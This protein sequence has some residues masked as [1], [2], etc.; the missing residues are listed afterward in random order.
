MSIRKRILPRSGD[1]RWQVDYRDQG[2]KRRAK[3]FTTKAAAVSYET[4]ARGE[5]VAGTHVADSASITVKEAATIWL[6]SCEARKL[7]ESSVRSYRNHVRRHIE[8]LIGDLKRSRR[9]RR[10]TSSTGSRR[11]ATAPPS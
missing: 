6:A 1:V 3:Q 7:E 2:G 11:G 4:K 8:P 5:L 9:L 10:R